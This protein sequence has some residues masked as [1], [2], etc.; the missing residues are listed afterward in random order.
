MS[1]RSS[2]KIEIVGEMGGREKKSGGDAR[3]DRIKY[4]ERGRGSITSGTHSAVYSTTPKRA[5]THVC[6][7]RR[8]GGII[9]SIRFDLIE[10]QTEGEEHRFAFP[11][12][13]TEYGRHSARSRL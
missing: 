13:N 8:L 10:I 3:L 1:H 11:V 9:Y 12:V 6:W 2:A 5:I 7:N 4:L